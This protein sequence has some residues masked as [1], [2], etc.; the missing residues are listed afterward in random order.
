M[1]VVYLA[2]GTIFGFILSRSGAADYNYIQGMFL[3]E[4]FQLYGIIATAVV[5]TAPGV[6]LIKR[7]GRT[8]SGRTVSA[9]TPPAGSCPISGGA[10][11]RSDAI[12]GKAARRTS[13]D[14][15]R[16]DP[17]AMHVSGFSRLTALIN[18]DRIPPPFVETESQ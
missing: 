5:L 12:R 10:K 15:Q 7:R 9:F 6:L 14:R 11:R 16:H 13:Q 17:S 8:V 1:R 3:L 2:L 18:P 4:E